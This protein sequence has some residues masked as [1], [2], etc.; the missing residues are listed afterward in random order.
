MA[1]PASPGTAFPAGDPRN[2]LYFETKGKLEHER[3]RTLGGLR[4]QRENAQ[5]NAKYRE[6]VMTG[7]EPQTYAANRYRAVR[8]GIASSGSNTERRGGIATNY[9][10]RRFAVQQGLKQTEGRI[11]RSE[12]EARERADQGIA[13]AGTRALEEAR[14][15]AE[16]HPPVQPTQAYNAGGTREVTGPPGPG[17]VVPYTEQTPGGFVRVG[18]APTIKWSR[19]PAVRRL[20]A[21]RGY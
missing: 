1:A 6:G 13:G 12:Q 8:E 5:G 9:A 3:E 7:Q 21:L 19:D 16:E 2:A 20:Q 11:S 15:Y 17:G 4:E 14:R 18:A 10:N